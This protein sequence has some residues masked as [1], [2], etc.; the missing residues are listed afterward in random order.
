L[1]YFEIPKMDKQMEQEKSMLEMELTRLMQKT[2][3]LE[4]ELNSIILGY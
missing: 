2:L 1:F 4:N 3:N